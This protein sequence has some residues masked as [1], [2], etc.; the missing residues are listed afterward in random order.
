MARD[1]F[2]DPQVNFNVMQ[3]CVIAVISNIEHKIF[4]CLAGILQQQL[5]RGL[6]ILKDYFPT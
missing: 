5:G 3:W 6:I 1:A 4:L 2:L